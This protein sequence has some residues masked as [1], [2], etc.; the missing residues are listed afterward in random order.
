MTRCLLVSL[1]LASSLLSVIAVPAVPVRAAAAAGDTYY[2]APDGSDDASGSR[3]QPWRSLEK[4]M[5]KLR[6]GD[7]LYVRGGRYRERVSPPTLQPGTPETPIRVVAFPLERPIIEGR[8]RVFDADHWVFDGLNVTSDGGTYD[9]GDNLVKFMD[10]TGWTFRDAEIWNGRTHGT[11]L[12]GSLDDSKPEPADWRIVGNCIHD[13]AD[14]GGTAK[15]H[16]IYATPGLKSGP[17]LIERNILYGAPNGTNIKLAGPSPDVGGAAYVTVRHNVMHDAEQNVLVAW[18]SHH[19]AIR[20]NTMGLGDPAPGKSWYPNIRGFDLSGDTN[21]ARGNVAFQ[22]ET[23]ILNRGADPGPT[24]GEVVDGGGNR[25]PEDPLFDRVGSCDGFHAGNPSG[26]VN[27]P[28]APTMGDVDPRD[29]VVRVDGP[30]RIETAVAASRRTFA[31][32]EVGHAILARADAYPD[33]LA[34][35][36]LAAALGGP[37][38]LTFG[39]VLH[40]TV[41]REID[42]LGVKEVTLLGG[43]AA[44]SGTIADQLR[45]R[46]ISVGRISG[47]NRFETAAEVARELVAGG[48]EPRTTYVVEGADPDPTRGW[49][50]AVSV[51]FLAASLRQPIVLVTTD[52]VPSATANVVSELGLGHGV[53]VGGEAAVDADV[54]RTLERE[55]GMSVDRVWGSSRYETSKA[56]VDHALLEGV[57]P[58][59]LWVATGRDYPDALAAG[60]AVAHLGGVL[61]LIDGSHLDATPIARDWVVEH[62]D[63]IQRTTLIGGRVAISEPVEDELRRRLPLVW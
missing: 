41:A 10:G 27:G 34:G 18:D 15:D 47:A 21:V 63:R 4:S 55:L 20:N 44:L 33:A 61:L 38:L 46:G 60:P 12:I 22:S 31:A 24:P 6:A 16:L 56:V 58:D 19:N 28:R 59:H 53:V 32:G 57:D 1:A 25:H 9:V 3:S 62:R 14:L 42:R 8:L 17:G 23:F 37:I 2:V 50:D 40:A 48:A 51:G 29:H 35:A 45:D 5:A 30:G 52:Q 43:E 54:V 7:T 39:D 36:P 49:P 26:W 11:F 13:A